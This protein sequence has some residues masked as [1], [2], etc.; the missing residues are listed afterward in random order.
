ML[1]GV[2]TSTYEAINKKYF[3]RI[4]K[5]NIFRLTVS[6]FRNYEVINEVGTPNR[7]LILQC[8]LF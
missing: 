2:S 3:S 4:Q 5:P 8:K 7:R 1:L 6:Q